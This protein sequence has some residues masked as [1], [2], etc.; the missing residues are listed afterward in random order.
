MGLPEA[1]PRAWLHPD[2]SVSQTGLVSGS[3]KPVLAAPFLPVHRVR[4]KDRVCRLCHMV[5]QGRKYPPPPSQAVQTVNQIRLAQGR[6][7]LCLCSSISMSVSFPHTVTRKHP[8]AK[9]RL[10]MHTHTYKHPAANM[11]AHTHTH[12]DK[13]MHAYTHTRIHI[14]AHTW[15][16]IQFDAH[17]HAQI[18]AHACTYAQED[19]LTHAR[20]TIKHCALTHERT[21]TQT[22][23]IHSNT[24]HT[25]TH[26]STNTHKGTQTQ[27]RK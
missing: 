11:Q 19:T 12:T 1:R 4:E 9:I 16:C 26:T 6:P 13:H 15:K 8:A 7:S 5:V 24:Q 2:A 25:C 3:R 18:Q 10:R 27:T 22:H 21:C 23:K 20:N 17:T 14:Q